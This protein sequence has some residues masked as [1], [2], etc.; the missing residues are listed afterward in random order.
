[1]THM[2]NVQE[3]KQESAIYL[4]CL[5]LDDTCRGK[6]SAYIT[7]CLGNIIFTI[8]VFSSYSKQ[9]KRMI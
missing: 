6:D 7:L 2:A 8:W 4:F 3:N 5:N 1:M 9:W